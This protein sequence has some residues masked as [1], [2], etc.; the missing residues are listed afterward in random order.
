MLARGTSRSE[1]ARG[2]GKPRL[3]VPLG[4]AM[5]A[6]L[7]GEG[8]PGDTERIGRSLGDLV[9]QVLDLWAAVYCSTE[10]VIKYQ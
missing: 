5:F 3:D 1:T 7:L 10:K 6:H 2:P 4:D 8:A 9:P